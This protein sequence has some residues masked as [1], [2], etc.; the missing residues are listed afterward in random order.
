MPKSAPHK[1][2]T[3]IASGKLIFDGK[4]V[5]QRVVPGGTP[6]VYTVQEKLQES[7]SQLASSPTLRCTAHL[8]VRVL[9]CHSSVMSLSLKPEI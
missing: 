8:R 2:L 7:A 5:L 3:L 6:D 9:W 1:A 4:V